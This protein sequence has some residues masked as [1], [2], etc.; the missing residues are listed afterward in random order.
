MKGCCRR[1]FLPFFKPAFSLPYALLFQT[2]SKPAEA[3]KIPR[4]EQFARA[5]TVL[6]VTF[7]LTG[8]KIERTEVISLK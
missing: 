2:S 5:K 6:R 8:Q 4:T 7:Q 3:H 1:F